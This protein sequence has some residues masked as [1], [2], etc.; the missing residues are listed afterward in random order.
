MNKEYSFT[1][2]LL[3]SSAELIPNDKELVQKAIEAMNKAYA[4]Y[5]KFKVG[6]SVKLSNGEIVLGNNQENIAYPSGLCAERVALFYVGATFPGEVIDTLCIVAKGD[7]VPDT[8]L[9]SP[10]GSCRQVMLESESRQSTPIRVILV[11]QDDSV[12]IVDSVKYFLPFGF[13][14]VLAK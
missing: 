3:K 14:P 7:L 9:L 13:G 5:S 1:Y 4:P 10:C 2:K 6:A 11:N 8:A 12:V